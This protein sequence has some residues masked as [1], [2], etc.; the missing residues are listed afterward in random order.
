MEIE[1][2]LHKQSHLRFRILQYDRLSILLAE[3]KRKE[4]AEKGG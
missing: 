4:V 1:K 3:N 2:T